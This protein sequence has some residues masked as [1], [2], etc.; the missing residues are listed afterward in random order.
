MNI[1]KIYRGNFDLLYAT[2]I[3]IALTTFFCF[4]G[5]ATNSIIKLGVM[6]LAPIIFLLRG[7][8]ISKA[9]IFGIGYWLWC[10]FSSLFIGEQRFSTLG[11]T[12]MYIITFIVF[13]NYLRND[14]FTFSYFK[15][16]LR[17]II[18][19]F[20]VVL[21]CQQICMLVGLRIMPIVNL[22]N[23]AFLSVT[24]LPILTLEPSHSAR[25]M[26]ALALCYWRMYQMEYGEKLKLKNLFKG[27]MKLP[28]ILFFWS[29]LT[30][31]S[32]TAFIALGILSLYFIT[33][34]TYLYVM[35]F[36]LAMYLI[37][38]TME[39]T[40]FERARR[41]ADASLT[42]DTEMIQEA[43]GSGASRIIPVINTITKTDLSNT[44]T[45]V[46]KGTGKIDSLWW[47][48]MDRKIGVIDQYGI[49]G[50]I[51]SMLLVYCCMIRRFISIETLFFI[52][53]LG[54]SIGNIY[55]AWGCLTLFA[56]VRYFQEQKEQGILIVIEENERVDTGF[57]ITKN[58]E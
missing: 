44:D 27:E 2:A 45:W 14:V 37:S 3:V 35:P 47:T 9:V 10:Y 57:E 50:F 51:I 31:G 1:L 18:M 23:Q 55:Y 19:A 46:G 12:G 28:M 32:G 48:K 25:I 40:Q 43:D 4:E 54:M 5:G 41:L 7:A 8:V 38:G 42:G 56:G 13:Y 20:G 39:L 33:K 36:M 21:I 15:Q 52:G 16:L 29:M 17:I 58:I 24:K 6:G 49:I 53:L 30:M 26:A 34:E 22:N 11:F